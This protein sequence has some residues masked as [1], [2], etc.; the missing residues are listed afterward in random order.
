MAEVQYRMV[1]GKDMLPAAE[2]LASKG[3]PV[4]NP[5]LAVA[6]V[7]EREG[8]VVGVLS[9]DALPMV[10]AVR[11]DEFEQD[12]DIGAQLFKQAYGYAKD[13]LK[14]VY[15]HTAHPTMKKMIERIGGKDTE[16]TWYR[17]SKE[18]S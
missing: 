12:A 1:A 10:S 4:P 11:V 13:N 7:A 8:K 15:M 5:M 16:E 3:Y 14:Q 6:F 17:W 18:G 9:I 2:F